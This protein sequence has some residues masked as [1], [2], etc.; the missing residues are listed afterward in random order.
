MNFCSYCVRC[1]R[2][3]VILLAADISYHRKQVHF[4]FHAQCGEFCRLTC[5]LTA[6]VDKRAR[7]QLSAAP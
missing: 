4:F 3:A 2:Y 1:M 6:F 5:R 7:F